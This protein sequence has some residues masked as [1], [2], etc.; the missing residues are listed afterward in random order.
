MASRPLR[1]R[2]VLAVIALAVIGL[3]VWAWEP[4]WLWA[5]TKRVFEESSCGGKKIRGWHTVSRWTG[6]DLGFRLFFVENGWLRAEGTGDDPFERVTNWNMDGEVVHQAYAVDYDGGVWTRSRRIVVT[7]MGGKG[8]PWLWGVSDQ[9][10]PTMPA[11]MKDN[12]KWQ[13]A[14]D[15]QD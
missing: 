3:G 15:A 5:T 7:S 1:A 14:L 11:W 13:A 12:A 2:V 4:V 6:D 9:T 10:A 8:P